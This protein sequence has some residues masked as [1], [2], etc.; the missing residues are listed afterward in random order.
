MVTIEDFC[1]AINF[2]IS[3]GS[4][5]QW[6][7]FGPYARYLDCNTD[8]E[9]INGR[10]SIHAVFDSNDQTVYAIEAWD[11]AN[12]RE[13]RWINP[14]YVKEH[15]AECA[16]RDVDLYESMDGRNYIE[17]DVANDILEK[18]N[19]LVNGVDYDTRVQVEVTL[20]DD[21]LF[22]AMKLAHEKD[23]T[24]NELVEEALKEE[25]QRLKEQDAA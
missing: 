22:R 24:L 12:E 8:D 20:E 6:D 19:A 11:Y 10:Y 16:R 18:A 14:A 23:I 9:G 5:Y 3:G 13:Y 15:M 25:I 4:E 7:C 1:K 17:L 21:I 2:R